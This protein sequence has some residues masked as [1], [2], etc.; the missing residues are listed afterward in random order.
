MFKRDFLPFRF[1]Q[2][3]RVLSYRVIKGLGPSYEHFGISALMDADGYAT[4]LSNV[5]MFTVF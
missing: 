2:K 5:Y 4:N 1:T 3:D